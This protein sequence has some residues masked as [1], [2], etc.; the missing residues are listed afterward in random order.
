ML[1]VD[2]A[3][4][5]SVGLESWPLPVKLTVPLGKAPDTPNTSVPFSIVVLV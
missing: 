4:M 1:I 5:S 3:R 2:C